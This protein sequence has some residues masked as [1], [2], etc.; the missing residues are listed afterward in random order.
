MPEFLTETMN[1][2]C[3]LSIWKITESCRNLIDMF[4]PFPDD[5]AKFNS[6]SHPAKKAECVASRLALKEI[7]KIS[8]IPYQ[9]IS[10]DINRKPYLTGTH[11]HISFSHSGEYACALLH[12]TK[13]IAVDL[14]MIREKLKIV[15]P[16]ILNKDELKDA[17]H[18]TCKLAVYWTCKEVVY[19]F[20]A[21]RK[22]SFKEDILIEPFTFTPEGECMAGL[23]LNRGY[24]RF[25]IK[26]RHFGD[27]IIAYTYEN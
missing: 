20:H 23:K 14:E 18:D 26:Y 6:I 1:E 19:K 9:G 3:S 7:L 12:K 4:Q 15:C 11:Y 2:N 21:E 27:Y 17:G 25:K 22:L 8:K 24:I 13:N 16:R 5:Q 10:Y